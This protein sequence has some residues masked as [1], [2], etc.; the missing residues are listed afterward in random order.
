MI[1]FWNRYG[2]KKLLSLCIW[3][4]FKEQELYE[5]EGLRVKKIEFTDNEDCIGMSLFMLN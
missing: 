2:S 5:K 3:L 4:Y 1:A